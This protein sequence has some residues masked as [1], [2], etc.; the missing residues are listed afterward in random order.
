MMLSKMLQS[1]ILK[2]KKRL[3]D[4]SW[5]LSTAVISI[6][7]L[8]A[9]LGFSLKSTNVSFKYGLITADIPVMPVPL[10]D[11]GFNNVAISPA[12]EISLHTPAIVMTNRQFYFG[13]MEAFTEKFSDIR[14]KFLITHENGIPQTPKLL[15]ALKIWHSHQKKES[16][17]KLVILAPSG[18]IKANDVAK[19]I[20]ELKASKLYDHVVLAGGYL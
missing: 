20:Y 4:D 16:E 19:V 6:L 1:K 2:T 10:D 9:I 18:S 13:S 7:G 14:N 3:S 12:A 17:D 8:F 11:S 5:L 15:H